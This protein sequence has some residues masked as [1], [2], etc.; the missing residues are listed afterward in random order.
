[1]G[2][3]QSINQYRI[4]DVWHQIGLIR[5][6][7]SQSSGLITEPVN[8]FPY[9]DTA[10]FSSHFNMRVNEPFIKRFVFLEWEIRRCYL[11]IPI[12]EIVNLLLNLYH[13]ISGIIHFNFPFVYL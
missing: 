5:N 11:W 4:I 12:Q 10:T 8:A 2:L 1:M 6:E 7:V 3:Q 9:M 13:L